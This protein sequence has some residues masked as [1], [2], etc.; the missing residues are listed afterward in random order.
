VPPKADISAQRRA[1]IIDAALACFMRKGYTNTTMDDIVVESGLS[2]GTLYWYFESKDDLLESAVASYFERFGDSTV[3]SLAECSTASERL[4][5]GGEA[6]VG[7][8]RQ[9]QGLFG[10]FLEFWSQSER[11]EEASRTW[12]SMLSTYAGM[13]A[14]FIEEGTRAGEFKE[15]DA[16]SLAW[17]ILAAYDGLA[18]YMLMMPDL[19][20]DRVSGIFV[21]TLL[22][23]LAV[24]GDGDGA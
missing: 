23:G 3:D 22:S 16:H 21:E 11:R 7:F 10:L 12:T 18:V 4:R 20:L 19:D 13:V 5:C 14:A 2:K 15:V 24:E 1:E 9:A 8:C 6:M 17:A